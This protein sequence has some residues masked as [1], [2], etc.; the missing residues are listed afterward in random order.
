MLFRMLSSAMMLLLCFGLG[1]CL[2]PAESEMD[3]G[4]NPYF[5][6]GKERVKERD[7]PGAIEAFQQALKENPRS[8]LAHYE[9]GM[10]YEQ[11]GN[12]KEE[13]YVAA[14]FH[15]YQAIRLRPN[16]YPSENAL[17]RIPG[18]KQE[19]LKSD[20]L[21]TVNPALFRD[22]EKLREE[23]RQLQ[24]QLEMWQT[25]WASRTAPSSSTNHTAVAPSPVRPGPSPN[26]APRG[27]TAGPTATASGKER[28]TP[29]PPS[30]PASR[31]R[32]YIVKRGD[33]PSAIARQHGVKLEALTAAN[34]S[35]NPRRLKIGQTLTIPA[36]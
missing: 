14:M 34:P 36:Q 17:Q 15:Y 13:D 12:P 8:A 11:H 29:P 3:E 31:V 6:K 9:L 19:L 18:C 7:Y 16:A 1:G 20:A 28:P 35:L 25:Q 26:P 5:V 22:L 10:L 4:K 27:Q 32:T 33:T 21:L 30:V 23:N 2:P 24:K